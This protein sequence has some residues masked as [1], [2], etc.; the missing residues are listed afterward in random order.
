MHITDGANVSNVCKIQVWCL[1]KQV[2]DDLS[3]FK[4][5]GVNV[6]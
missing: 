3:D 1:H 4:T 6:P 2:H 5:S